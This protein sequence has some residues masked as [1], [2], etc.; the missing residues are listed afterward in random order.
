MKVWELN[1]ELSIMQ[2]KQQGALFMRIGA[3]LTVWLLLLQGASAETDADVAAASESNWNGLLLLLF[4]LGEQPGIENYIAFMRSAGQH[5]SAFHSHVRRYISE[6]LF[7]F[8]TAPTHTHAFFQP[9]P[10]ALFLEIVFFFIPLWSF[11]PNCRCKCS[12]YRYISSILLERKFLIL[13]LFFLFE[14]RLDLLVNCHD[15]LI[16]NIKHW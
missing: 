10:L 2:K 13:I 6:I 14:N 9:P 1:Q 12:R 11:L 5:P 3:L 8:R 4:F 15:R 16:F 7:M